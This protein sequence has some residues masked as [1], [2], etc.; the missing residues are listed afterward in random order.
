MPVC[1]PGLRSARPP[2][3]GAS[4]GPSMKF[5]DSE[6][7]TINVSSLRIDTPLGRPKCRHSSTNAKF[8]SSTCT[9]L[10]ERSATNSRPR[11]S[12]ANACGPMNWPG[13]EPRLPTAR[14]KV[15]SGFSRTMRSPSCC[16]LA[17]RGQCPSATR[18][19][20]FAATAQAVGPMKVSVPAARDACLTEAEQE[21]AVLRE[22]VQLKAATL[23]RRVL[24]ERSA[25]ADPEVAVMIHAEAVA[26]HE[27]PAAEALRDLA[28]LIDVVNRRLRA[29]H[30]PGAALVVGDDPDRRAPGHA[31]G[32]RRP[33]LDDAIRVAHRRRRAARE[34]LELRRRRTVARLLRRDCAAE[35]DAAR[36]CEGAE[37]GERCGAFFSPP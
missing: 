29:K 17:G 3:S 12:N 2:P 4:G 1:Q 24:G 7:A 16:A 11:E 22:L 32:Q 25:V 8:S 14:T 15:P 23:G 26:L 37:A 6:S 36:R 5:V 9:R 34:L 35:H 33:A 19:S 28:G 21:L 13:P 10:L 18:M 31:V 30:H 27:Q 20:P